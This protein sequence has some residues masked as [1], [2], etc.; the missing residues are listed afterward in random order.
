MTEEETMEIS[1]SFSALAQLDERDTAVKE[2][3]VAY[4]M[5]HSGEVLDKSTYPNRNDRA[6]RIDEL[7]EL[8]IGRSSLTT[9][10]R[11]DQRRVLATHSLFT[12]ARTSR[13]ENPSTIV[14]HLD[15]SV[16]LEGAMI[17]T[18]DLD[19]DNF[20]L[21]LPSEMA[22]AGFSF[23][24]FTDFRTK[25][26]DLGHHLIT[27]PTTVMTMLE[28][29]QSLFLEKAITNYNQLSTFH[30]IVPHWNI[31]GAPDDCNRTFENLGLTY[32]TGKTIKIQGQVS[33]V[34]DAMT[35]YTQ[36]AFRCR[37]FLVYDGEPSDQRCNQI[38]MIPQ[39]AEEGIITKPV[40]CWSCSG[41][42]DFVKLDSEKSRI[43]PVQRIQLQELNLSEEPKAIMVELRGNLVK[44]VTAGS[45]I[46]VTGI[47]RLESITK[48]SLLSTAYILGQSIT[49]ISEDSFV[50]VIDATDE[51]IIED[52]VVETPSLQ[53]RVTAIHKAW[54]GHLLCDEKL[55]EALVMQVVG[56]PRDD[57]FGHRSGIH[58][59][60]AGDPGTAKSHLLKSVPRISNGSRYLSAD[61]VSKAG[62]TGACMQVEDLY[63]GKKRWSIV[64]GALA[65]TP[66]EA[67]C[68]VDEFNLYPGDFG[69]FNNAMESGMTTINKIVKGTVYTECS[70]LAGANP[71]A[72]VKKKFARDQDYVSQLGLDITVMQRFD[73][74]FILLDDAKAKTDEDIALSMLGFGDDSKDDIVDL[75][76]IKKYIAYVKKI[77]PKLS[78][79]AANYM[80]KQHAKK[81]QESKDSDYFR[82]HRQ[83][84]SLKRFSLAVARFDLSEEVTIE[85]V[86]FA[87]KIL[88]STLSEQDPGLMVG[89]EPK[90]SRE[91]RQLVA[92]KL[93]Q[94]MQEKNKYENLDPDFI[95]QWMNENDLQ[96]TK[97]EL[98]SL[99][100]EFSKTVQDL[101][102]NKDGTYDYNGTMSPAFSMW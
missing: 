88:Q 95:H 19:G 68:C 72:G 31:V 12:Q 14:C 2:S 73:A 25:Y 38:N 47:L 90:E 60:I 29:L 7:G 102:K 99:L 50:T 92:R 85:H 77:D 94:Y 71:N 24:D 15:A 64:P 49:T 35:V 86:K 4:L 78:R 74:I 44:K 20:T 54:I 81:R 16:I 8:A 40:E 100:S 13:D 93:I 89:A 101:K 28:H 61:N 10:I 41:K 65:L 62:L 30:T 43:E 97:A 42:K 87:E 67:T 91:H 58:I 63:T 37:N 70:V 57:S 46:E 45:T 75:E 3:V 21:T 33:E 98:K 53:E 84:A 32:D 22:E 26:N 34:G 55:K 6:R 17:P 52:W 23:I 1:E 59:L 11:S 96:I 56:A 9:Q 83:V 51:A 66:K 36:I 82:S 18:A 39:A 80:A 5:W 76:F 27:D 48:N 79:E 69:D